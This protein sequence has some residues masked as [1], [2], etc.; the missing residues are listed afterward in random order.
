ME[1]GIAIICFVNLVAWAVVYRRVRRPLRSIANGAELLRARDFGSRLPHVG[2]R[3]ADKIID[4]FNQMM[5]ALKEERLRLREQNHFLD[6]LIEV[7]P[8]G[9]IQLDP[10]DVKIITHANNA[11]ASML[12]SRE[13]SLL[14][15]S[16]LSDVPGQL[17][18]EISTLKPDE[19]RTVR[20]NN[21]MIYRCSRFSFMERGIRH[22]FI[23]VESLTDEVRQ[24]ERKSY[25][26][27]LR[28]IA[29]EVNNSLAGIIS[30]SETVAECTEDSDLKEALT[31]GA[32]RGKDL[33]AFISQLAKSVKIPAPNC[34]ETDLPA[35]LLNL[36]PML[37]A[38]C[39]KTG[40]K[41]SYIPP[42]GPLQVS[43]D[44]ILIEQVITNIVK[45]GAESA[46]QGGEV[47]LAVDAS[48]RT[49]TVTDNGPGLSA[50]SASMLF[51]PFYTTKAQGQG[52]GLLVVS[53]ILNAHGLKF[54]LATGPD[55][56]TRFTVNL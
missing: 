49:L 52:L 8:M 23:L 45:N 37:E 26:K 54:S 25:E 48:S 1:F 2:N 32:Q 40:A 35:M 7:S 11:A 27:V 33:G 10:A 5:T 34:V 50:E 41:F 19:V 14:A 51:T 43:L 29:H 56:L 17:A 4:M 21:A 16:V 38:L 42:G 31:A 36:S 24:A 39:A 44:P 13:A 15:G 3:D 46:G 9:I 55:A 22:P 47:E 20:L 6:L 53:E 12:D 30:V 28:M 18:S